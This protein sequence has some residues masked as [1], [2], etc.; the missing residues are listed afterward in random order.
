MMTDLELFMKHVSRHNFPEEFEGSHLLSPF[1]CPTCDIKGT[2]RSGQE[3]EHMMR[4][5]GCNLVW[6]PGTIQAYQQIVLEAM[7]NYADGI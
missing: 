6:T 2:W 5:N 7:P 3:F 1:R 4:C